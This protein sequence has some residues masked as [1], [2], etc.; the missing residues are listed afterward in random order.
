MKKI[1]RESDMTGFLG[2][3]V[4]ANSAKCIIFSNATFYYIL[5][6]CRADRFD[7]SFSNHSHSL[8]PAI[9]RYLNPTRQRP[10]QRHANPGSSPRHRPQPERGQHQ[11]HRPH[12]QIDNH[13]I[14]RVL[15]PGQIPATVSITAVKHAQQPAI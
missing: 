3:G 10:I 11:K 7:N 1:T 2:G 4:V 12:H 13:I 15:D 5:M 9:L 8:P 6:Q 14:L